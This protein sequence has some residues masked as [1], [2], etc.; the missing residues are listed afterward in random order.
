MVLNC[1]SKHVA[2][3]KLNKHTWFKNFIKWFLKAKN[4]YQSKNVHYT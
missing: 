4:N 2:N 1:K 3:F